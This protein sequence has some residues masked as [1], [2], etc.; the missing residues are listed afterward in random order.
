[1]IQIANLLASKVGSSLVSTCDG[2]LAAVEGSYRF[3][4]NKSISSEAIAE[5]GFESTVAKAHAHGELLALE[6]TTSFNYTHEVDG[7]E[8]VH[9]NNGNARGFYAHSM[10]LID[11]IKEETIG[12]VGQIRWQR[13]ISQRGRR[14]KL[15]ERDYEE[16][17]SIKWQQ[18]SEMMA[19]RLG[20][21]LSDVISVCDREADIYDYLYYKQTHK[22]RFI[23]RAVRDRHLDCSDESISEALARSK[24]LGH[25]DVEVAQK[26]GR[27]ARKA[28]LELRSCSVVLKGVKRGE[29]FLDEISVNVICA[30]EINN[31]N[32]STNHLSWVILTS[33]EVNNLKK[34][35]KVIQCYEM[36]WRIEEFHKAW[37]TGVGAEKQRMQSADNLEKMIVIL[38]F[39]A[40][41]LLQLREA[42]EHKDKK[43]LN[44]QKCTTVLTQ[45]EFI[46]L[47]YATQKKR[48]KS[49]AV[50]CVP[51]GL[52]WAY[53]SIAKLGGWINSKKTGKAS[54]LTIWK[55]WYRLQERVDGFK[56][57]KMAF[58]M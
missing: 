18:S 3:I 20:S 25:C 34:V 27:P 44:T 55:G 41:R 26:S 29:S 45:E 9:G 49:K 30:T 15:R 24:V 36:R 58:K 7:L 43:I 53:E 19:E 32:T 5:G 52:D 10:L 47:W 38:G 17:E 2:D 13:K 14:Y 16:K 31:K 12:L 8:S 46:V 28:T 57:A 23:V 40:I 48:E 21:K 4:R 56:A 51:P 37:K 50:P 54:W 6:D 11:P 22:Q 33:E 39:V 35:K 1:L 42:F